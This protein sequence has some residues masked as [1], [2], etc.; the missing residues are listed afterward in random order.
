MINHA[1]NTVLKFLEKHRTK[2]FVFFVVQWTIVSAF[3]F[4]HSRDVNGCISG[5]FAVFYAILSV[6]PPSKLKE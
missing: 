5:F 2:F 1:F 6:V 4:G 3:E